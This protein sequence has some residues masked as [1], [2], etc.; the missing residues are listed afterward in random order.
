VNELIVAPVVAR[1]DPVI[2]FIEGQQKHLQRSGTTGLV[3]QAMPLMYSMEREKYEE[4]GRLINQA[5]DADPQNAKAAAW[6]AHWQ[7]F[8]VGQGWAQDPAHAFVNAQEL[9]IKAIRLDP[10]NAE[11]IG[12]Y[13]H[14]CAFLDK[15]FDSAVH[16]F[17]RALRLNPNLAFI[18]AL[19]AA[20]YCYIGEPHLALERLDRCRDLAPFDPYLRLW[21]SVYT[22]AY[23]FEGEY[24]R[25]ISVGRRAV[26][27]NP[28]F[29]NGYKPLIAAFGH[30]GRRADAAPYLSKLLSLEPTFTVEKFGRVY[31]FKK[32]EDRDRYMRGLVLAGVPET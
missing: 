1:I 17:D 10:E 27:A 14:V 9:A 20:T 30:L 25:A 24:E 26:K 16:Y 6:G 29:V 19:S 2:L 31:P 22:I 12:I 4:A 32:P 18:W 13:A 11:A 5:L 21:E 15:D 28:E 23:T 8:Y 3:L 7:V